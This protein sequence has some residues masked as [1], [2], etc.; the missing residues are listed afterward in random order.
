MVRKSWFIVFAMVL[1]FLRKENVYGEDSTEYYVE[2]CNEQNEDEFDLSEENSD[3]NIDVSRNEED[4]LKAEYDI[5]ISNQPEQ[6]SEGWNAIDGEYYY[7]NSNGDKLTGFQNIE[8]KCYYLDPESEG[9][10]LYGWRKIS[11]KWYYFGSAEDGAMRSGWQKICGKWYYLGNATDGAMKTGWQLISGKWY[12]LFPENN[13]YGGTYGAMASNQMIGNYYVAPSGEWVTNGM[14][15]IAQNYS[16]NTR[17]LILVDRNA[18]KVGIFCGSRNNW[19]LI[20][21]WDCA[22]GKPSTPTVTGQFTVGSKGHYFDSGD[23]RC[24]YFTQFKGNYLFH[25]V[26]YNKNGTLR[27]GRTGLQLSHGCVRLDIN[28]AKWIYDN[29]PA[30]TKVFVYN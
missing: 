10:R 22:P 19:N 6:L 15:Q 27:D 20:H 30:G 23:S 9:K 28:N 8:G 25:S 5:S 17:Y 29:I 24:Y 13:P 14:V 4:V 11:E 1:V 7:I 21:F 2:E 26:L 16:S 18:C 3:Q 12:Y